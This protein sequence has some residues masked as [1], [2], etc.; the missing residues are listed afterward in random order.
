MWGKTFS[1]LLLF[2][3]LFVQLLI[4]QPVG[5]CN[6]TNGCTAGLSWVVQMDCGAAC[7]VRVIVVLKMK[8][9]TTTNV[10]QCVG[11]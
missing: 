9:K 8:I 1:L 5:S 10:T 6:K 2:G 4:A 11:K 7:A 3:S